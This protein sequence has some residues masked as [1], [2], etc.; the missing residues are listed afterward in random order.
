MSLSQLLQISNAVE[1]INTTNSILA[2]K[3]ILAKYPELKEILFYVY[4]PMYIF[5]VTSKAILKYQETHTHTENNLETL[6]ELLDNL[7][8]RVYTG[9][10]AIKQILGFI[11]AN[12][13]F[14][15]LIL[16]IVDKD[17]K[18]RMGVKQIN[19]VFP[20]LIPEFEVALA[21]RFDKQT[22][23]FEKHDDWL[24]SRKLDGARCIAMTDIKNKSVTFN[25]RKGLEFTTLGKIR[26]ILV[27]HL[28]PTLT[29]DMVFDGEICIMVDGNESFTAI[30]K[31]IKKRGHTIET[32]CYKVFDYLTLKEF[33]SKKSTR[34]L[35]DRLKLCKKTVKKVDSPL[36]QYL[37]QDLNTPEIF[38]EL[39]DSVEK[40]NWE[41]LMLRRN[42]GYE[43][44]RSKNLLK[45]KKF[46]REEFMVANM[47]SDKISNN[48]SKFGNEM[49]LKNVKILYKNCNV[50]VGSGFS[51]E[52]RKYYH[53]NPDEIVG[54]V[55]SVQYF[56]EIST[57]KKGVETYS[58]R[59]PTF[60]GLY[61]V[62]REF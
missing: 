12:D 61:G 3:K 38:A 59:F 4:N 60:K 11:N 45:V 31:E 19:A 50:D 6:I 52:E 23:Y 8:N 17:L 1:D 21:D 39:L 16:K 54:K 56:E 42:V 49:G 43:G 7:R 13:L 44:K 40:Y 20:E 36:I 47:T 57:V 28:L 35:K 34:V 33:N 18:I 48:G 37:Q 5:S 26:D 58:L 27:K 51:C 2:K 29:E 32:P 25:S 14:Y 9:H 41:G 10:T 24:V 30:M 22:A 62:S 15:D 46:E 55:I 53:E